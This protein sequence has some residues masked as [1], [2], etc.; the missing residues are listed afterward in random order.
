MVMQSVYF[1][2][3]LLCASPLCRLSDTTHGFLYIS[4]HIKVHKDQQPCLFD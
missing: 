2:R 1:F 4:I 3:N